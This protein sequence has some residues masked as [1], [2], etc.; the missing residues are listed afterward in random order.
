MKRPQNPCYKCTKHAGCTHTGC[1]AYDKF[2]K[3]NAALNRKIRE[4]K[5]LDSYCEVNKRVHKSV[6]ACGEEIRK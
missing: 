5:R 6:K 1:A 4:E 2:V 3:E